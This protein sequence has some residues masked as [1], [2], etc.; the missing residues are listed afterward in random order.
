MN[1]H[2]V[3]REG[4]G[5]KKLVTKEHLHGLGFMY[6]VDKNQLFT[7]EKCHKIYIEHKDF[8]A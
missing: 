6:G 5:F 7:H 8:K 4:G 1:V 3:G 2:I